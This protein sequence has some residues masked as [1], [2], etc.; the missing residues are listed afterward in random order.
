MLAV[1]ILTGFAVL[2]AVYLFLTLLAG[3]SWIAALGPVALVLVAAIL[4][5]I[6]PRSRMF[7]TGLLIGLGA[8][9]LLA[10]GICIPLLI[11]SA[12]VA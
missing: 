10:G 2:F 5:A 4:L 9:A 8:W 1:G 6:R 12:G 11:P 7:G 3:P